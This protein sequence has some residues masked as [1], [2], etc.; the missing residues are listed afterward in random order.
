MREW[1]RRAARVLGLALLGWVGLS[2]LLVL[3]FRVVP[4]GGSMVM[5]ERK[6]EAWLAGESLDI[7]QQW[8]P[9][10]QLS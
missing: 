5:V 2:V 6:V 1:L 10:S 7:R 8:R 9:W 4:V 3:M